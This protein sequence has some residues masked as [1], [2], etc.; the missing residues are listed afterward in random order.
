MAFSKVIKDKIVRFILGASSVP[1]GLAEIQ[2]Y[3]RHNDPL[4]FRFEK[5]DDGSLVAMSTNFRYGSIIAHAKNHEELDKQIKD[6]IL[7]AFEIPSS[8]E[9]DADIRSTAESRYAPA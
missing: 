2:L 9:R 8:Y 7:T 3:F 5:Q 1:R 6:A 4:N